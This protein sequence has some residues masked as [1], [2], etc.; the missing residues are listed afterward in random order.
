MKTAN[1][2][3]PGGPSPRIWADCPV[4]TMQKDP[5]KGI[6]IFEDFLGKYTALTAGGILVNTPFEMVDDGGDAFVK[7]DTTAYDNEHGVVTLEPDGATAYDEVYLVSQVLYQLVMNSER[8]MW[9]EARIKLEDITADMSLIC[10][11]GDATLLAGTSVI[12][13]S[14]TPTTIESRDFVGFVAFTDG[15]KIHDIDAIY[16]EVGDSAVTQVKNAAFA[17][18]SWIN[19]TYVKLGLKF[20]GKKSL[21][22]YINGVE[23]GELDVDDFATVTANELTPLGMILGEMCGDAPGAGAAKELAVDWIRFACDRNDAQ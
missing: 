2:V 19:D 1:T 5:G 11:L 7:I 9:F 18:A 16:H 14:A 21:K 3:P 6:H 15:T 10:G 13:E 20:D 12:Q 8:R 22:Y 17:Q 23:V 4:V